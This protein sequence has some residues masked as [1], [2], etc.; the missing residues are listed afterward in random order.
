MIGFAYCFFGAKVYPVMHGIICGFIA[1]CVSVPLLSGITQNTFVGVLGAIALGT[2]AGM[3]CFKAKLLQAFVLGV[4]IGTV[5]SDLVFIFLIKQAFPH[6]NNNEKMILNFLLS[7][8]FGI[9]SCAYPH[10]MIVSGTAIF[11][12]SSIT[13]NV[14]IFAGKT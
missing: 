14:L 1:F 12:A 7:M 13:A 3:K 6:S 9:I 10:S 2:L 8:T 4:L 5:A 11:G